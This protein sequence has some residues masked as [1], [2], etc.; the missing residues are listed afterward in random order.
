[1]AINPKMTLRAVL[2]NDIENYSALLLNYWRRLGTSTP[3][4]AFRVNVLSK[5][6]FII[7]PDLSIFSAHSCVSRLFYLFKDFPR[8]CDRIISRSDW[9]SNDQKIGA[10]ANGFDWCHH[11]ALVIERGACRANAGRKNDEAG[12]FNRA[13][14]R[15]DFERRGHHAVDTGRFTKPREVDDFVF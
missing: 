11:A 1:M 4:T 12:I 5:H 2:T 9:P 7:L 8:G 3:R 13:S 10:R 15:S 6:G 14:D